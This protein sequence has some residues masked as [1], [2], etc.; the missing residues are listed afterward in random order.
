MNMDDYLKEIEESIDNLSSELST[1]SNLDINN[2]N[3]KDVKNY[4]NE[5]KTSNGELN[6]I[7]EKINLIITEDVNELSTISRCNDKLQNLKNTYNIDELIEKYANKKIEKYVKSIIKVEKHMNWLNSKFNFGFSELHIMNDEINDLVGEYSRLKGEVKDIIEL[8]NEVNNPYTISPKEL[9]ERL[10]TIKTGIKII[11]NKQINNYN[12]M[13]I[14]I[15]KRFDEVIRS[16]EYL[17]E[18]KRNQIVSMIPRERLEVYNGIVDKYDARKYLESLKYSELKEQFK[19]YTEMEKILDNQV[20]EH[21]PSEPVEITDY[22]INPKPEPTKL[23]EGNKAIIV[24]EPENT[25]IIKVSEEEAIKAELT[26]LENKI[27]LLNSMYKDNMSQ[28][29]L[30]KYFFT[31]MDTHTNLVITERE[32]L[33]A[34]DKIKNDPEIVNRLNNC[35]NIFKDILNKYLTQKNNPTNSESKSETKLLPAPDTYKY[36][37]DRI[38]KLEQRFEHAKIELDSLGKKN[39]EL[40]DEIHGYRIGS[41]ELQADIHGARREDKITIEQYKNLINKLGN[42]IEKIEKYQQ[43]I[44]STDKLTEEGFTDLLNGDINNLENGI[45]RFEQKVDAAENPINKEDKAL[46]DKMYEELNNEIDEIEE[47]IKDC[48][49]P[50]KQKNDTDRLNKCKEDLKKINK[51]YLSKCPL[52]VNKVRSAKKFFKEN[53]KI[54]LIVAGLA[55]LSILLAPPIIPAIMN[56][57]RIIMTKVPSLIS[58]LSPLNKF[59]GNSIGAKEVIQRTALDSGYKVWQFANGTL[60]SN[61]IPQPQVALL[62][63]LALSIG[64][65]AVIATPLI[66]GVVMAIKNLRKN[67]KTKKKEEKKATNSP[68]LEDDGAIEP[69]ETS[70]E[71]EEKTGRRR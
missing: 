47:K 39:P 14:S 30:Q 45:K 65:S 8:I 3:A 66:T 35:N 9:N 69:I 59:L 19:I 51:K 27:E 53:K 6:S 31:I 24:P 33:K 10:E 15:N 12:R 50:E 29:E 60:M 20:V 68:A 36:Y 52:R 71:L 54:I 55:A 5:L 46:L 70:E 57:N 41:Y 22:S 7:K 34:N 4:I 64:G 13:V 58:F 37:L 18:E 11:K 2:L 49:D 26:N 56:G 43:E 61:I 67:K 48:S 25:E 28:E 16:V 63:G 23:E 42:L 21:N 40:V 1:L 38:D 44:K 62:K 17:S 32:I